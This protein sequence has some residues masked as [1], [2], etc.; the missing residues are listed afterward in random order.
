MGIRRNG[1]RRAVIIIII[2]KVEVKNRVGG[3]RQT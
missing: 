2:K 3:R 1:T